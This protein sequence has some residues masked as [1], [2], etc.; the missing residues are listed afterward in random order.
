MNLYAVTAAH[1]RASPKSKKAIAADLGV[2][3]RW[4]YYFEN[5]EIRNPGVETTQH[6]YTYLTGKEI[7]LKEAV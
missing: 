5:E 4:L 1:L 3:F 7:K 6:L 2:S